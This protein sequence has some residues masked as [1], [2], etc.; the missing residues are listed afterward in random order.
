MKIKITK[1]IKNY[2]V[3][4]QEEEEILVNLNYSNFYNVSK[5]DFSIEKLIKK[6]NL[7]NT[8]LFLGI[9]RLITND[10]LENHHT[11]REKF[12]FFTME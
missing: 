8:K 6:V 3:L 5:A 11:Q 9:G 10:N 1:L 7:K 2:Q 4:L 12:S